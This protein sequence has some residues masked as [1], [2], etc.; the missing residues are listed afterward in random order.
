V[1][2]VSWTLS[3]SDAVPSGTVDWEQSVAGLR[4]ACVR[5]T[6]IGVGGAVGDRPDPLA[7]E[8]PA[9]TNDASTTA[10]GMSARLRIATMSP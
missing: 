9:T 4:D 8:Q 2:I 10:Q 1:L 3:V 7:A 6:T 5:G